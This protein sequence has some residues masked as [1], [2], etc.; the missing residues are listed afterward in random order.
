MSFRSLD[1]VEVKYVDA[2]HP[3]Q[4]PHLRVG[5]CMN[6]MGKE[7]VFLLTEDYKKALCRFC[8]TVYLVKVDHE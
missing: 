6:C 4:T 7:R 8:G 1:T 2:R 3:E 5:Q